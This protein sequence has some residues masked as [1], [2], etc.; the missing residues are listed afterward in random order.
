M[1][2]NERLTPTQRIYMKNFLQTVE[3][4]RAQPYTEE[5]IQSIRA[6]MSSEDEET[7][8]K[9]VLAVCPCRMSWEIFHEF[10]KAAKRLQQDVSPVVRANARHIEEDARKVASIEAQIENIEEFDA[11]DCSQ[12][13]RR[14]NHRRHP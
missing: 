2:R 8:A 13:N 9:A 10:R 1:P 5:D 11:G 3:N 6:G 12:K 14:Q 4:E 7:R